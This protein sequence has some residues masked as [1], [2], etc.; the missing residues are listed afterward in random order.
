MQCMATAVNVLAA[1]G[2]PALKHNHRYNVKV[3]DAS[4]LCIFG[5]KIDGR[6]YFVEPESERVF[7]LASPDG[8]TFFTSQNESA[9]ISAAQQK[10]AHRE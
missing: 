8:I 6:Y 1:Y 9:V 7:S 5:A 3:G 4:A 2:T 10:Y